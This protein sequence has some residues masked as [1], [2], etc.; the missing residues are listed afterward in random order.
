[1]LCDY[2]TFLC[3]LLMKKM[4]K[5]MLLVDFKFFGKYMHLRKKDN[6]AYL[7]M[8]DNILCIIY[9][10]DTFNLPLPLLK[11]YIYLWNYFYKTQFRHCLSGK[12]NVLQATS[13]CSVFWSHLH[14]SIYEQRWKMVIHLSAPE[15]KPHYIEITLSPNTGYH[16][17][18]N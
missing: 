11:V 13:N 7:S 9:R 14:F 6:F 18:S 5:K 17:V 3:N 15:T 2:R 8:K 10:K 1:M 4:H 16:I 12:N